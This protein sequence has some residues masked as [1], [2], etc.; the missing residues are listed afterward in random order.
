MHPVLTITLNPALD[1]T[2]AVEEFVPRLKLR[3]DTPRYDPGGGGINVSRAM[4]KLGGESLAFVA[5]GGA[6]GQQMERLL[7]EGGIDCEIWRS[8]GETRLSF[9]VVEQSSHEQYRFVLPGPEQTDDAADDIIAAL[10]DLLRRGGYRYVVASGSLPPGLPRDLYGRMAARCR[11]LDVRLILDTSGPALKAALSKRPFLIKPDKEEA[12]TLL[13][14]RAITVESGAKAAQRLLEQEAAEAV[15]LTLGAEGAI[16]ADG[17]SLFHLR[18][19]Y[20]P[21]K[22][23]VGAGDSFV[24]ALTLGLAKEWTLEDAGRYAVAAAASAVTTEATALCDRAQTEEFFDV[25]SVERLD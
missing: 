24:A 22:S 17:V 1:I 16:V 14:V 8:A 23:M 6:T 15:I 12:L 21:V 19:P 9:Q 25:I 18:P 20:V 3:C 4:K 7:R 2:T 11:E 10:T 5:L 13:E